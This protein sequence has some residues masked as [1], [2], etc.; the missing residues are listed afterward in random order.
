MNKRDDVD[1]PDMFLLTSFVPME[2]S[3]F[4]IQRRYGQRRSVRVVFLKL[5]D[6]LD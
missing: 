5:H 2:W 1:V 4:W 3:N 6:L